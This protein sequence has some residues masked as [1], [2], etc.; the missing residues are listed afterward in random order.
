M[1]NTSLKLYLRESGDPDGP[2]VVFLHGGPLSS[3]MWEPQLEQLTGLHCLAPD[4][5]GHGASD[6]GEPFT[7]KDAARQV[8]DLI[9][10]KTPDG[11]A[12]VVG[13]SLGGAVTL[14]LLRE[15]PSVV[16][17]AMVSGTAARLDKFTGQLS[18]MSTGVLRLISPEKQ[19]EMAVR[20]FGIPPQY[21]DLVEDDLIRG[22]TESYSRSMVVALMS[23]DLPE[24]IDCPLL[25]A[26]GERET[27]PA[28]Q[29]A[30]KLLQLYRGAQG[31]IVPK[32]NHLWN[33]QDPALFNQTVLA[34]VTEQPLPERLRIT[35]RVA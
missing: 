23:M 5:P 2:P 8:A 30:R 13:L 19:A 35:T 21:R 15:D 26:V 17:R 14:T 12:A 32:M 16:A 10:E 3:K 20:Q 29:A 4:L 18:L 34:W 7:L 9:R 25:V 31:V 6:T 28:R 22:S 33:L 11:K 24:M 27:I 1:T